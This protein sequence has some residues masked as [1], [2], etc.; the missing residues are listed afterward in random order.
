M[1]YISEKHRFSM[2]KRNMSWTKQRAVLYYV[3][4]MKK[5]LPFPV[6][7]VSGEYCKR[8][9]WVHNFGIINIISQKTTLYCN[10][11]NAADKSNRVQ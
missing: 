11:E 10:A 4:I 1:I 2:M 7:N 3:L 6:A 5:N 8:Q 9:L